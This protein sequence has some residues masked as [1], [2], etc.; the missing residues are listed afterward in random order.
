VFTALENYPFPVLHVAISQRV[1]FAES[2]A[3]GQSVLETEPHG[4]AAQEITA[5]THE[6]LEM[7]THAEEDRTRNR[8]QTS[9]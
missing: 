4:T 9:C 5:F 1:A 7:M 3:L 8:H 2:A 6:V